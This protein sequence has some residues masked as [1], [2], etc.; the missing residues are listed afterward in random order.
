LVTDKQ[1]PVTKNFQAVVLS[2]WQLV[3]YPA[4]CK[5]PVPICLPHIYKHLLLINLSTTKTASTTKLV[6]VRPT[7]GFL[8]KEMLNPELEVRK[9]VSVSCL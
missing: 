6:T 7:R 9:E 1:H 8:T 5:N 4:W 3:E 2:L